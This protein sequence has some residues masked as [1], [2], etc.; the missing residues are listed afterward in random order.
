MITKSII[1]FLF[2]KDYT[3]LVLL[4]S[5]FLTTFNFFFFSSFQGYLFAESLNKY[6]LDTMY[7]KPEDILPTLWNIVDMN[8]EF[9]HWEVIGHSSNEKL[10]I[11]AFK[12]SNPNTGSNFSKPSV[13]FHGQ[14]HSEEPIGVEIVFFIGRYFISEYG[15]DSFITYLIDNYN[16]W[17]VPTI[18]PEGFR[19]VNRGLYRLKRKNNTDTNMNGVFEIDRDGVDLNRNY[20]FNWEADEMVDPESPYFKGYEPS[21]QSEIRA[22]IEFYDQKRFQLAFFYHS[23][24]S[25]TYSERIFFPWKWSEEE[26]PD[27]QEML[28]LAEILAQNLPRTYTKGNYIVHRFITSRIGFARDYIYSEHGTLAMLIEVGGNSPYGEGVINP[29]NNILQELMRNHTR[30]IIKLLQGYSKNLFIG[31]VKDYYE[32]PLSNVEVVFVDKQNPYKKNLYTNNRGFFFYYL[33]PSETPFPIT[34]NNLEFSIL[35]EDDQQIEYS[36]Y[37]DTEKDLPFFRNTVNSGE[38]II[39]TNPVFQ[40][41]PA[42]EIMREEVPNDSPKESLYLTISEGLSL[43]YR[44]EIKNENGVFNIP[45]IPTDLTN[46]GILTIQTHDLNPLLSTKSNEK[47]ANK[48]IFLQ[49]KSEI[50]TYAIEYSTLNNWYLQPETMIGVDYSLYPAG[51][52]D[53]SINEIRIVGNEEFRSD[54]LE[55]VLYA[56]ADKIYQTRYFY[57]A[58]EFLSFN[59]PDIPLPEDLF[60]VIANRGY[61][62]LSIYRE[63]GYTVPSNRMFVNYSEWQALNIEDLAIEIHLKR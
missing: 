34:I 50:L 33:K 15:K 60:I 57:S 30:G 17:F 56:G 25:G 10:P 16:L 37:I 21:S 11:Y 20:P 31:R 48:I 39:M 44:R 53:Y 43:L 6:P 61:Y 7:H 40:Y 54:H 14:H 2:N 29:P 55:L 38:A 28:Y 12:I 22:M 13:L 59:V 52:N 27:Y 4:I 23:S 19:I 51:I 42:L 36:F 63:S 8:P 46:K 24:A 5:F 26:S 32:L 58:V 62:P 47:L 41:F 35:K 1:V 9:V 49:E 18:N 45:W 3:R